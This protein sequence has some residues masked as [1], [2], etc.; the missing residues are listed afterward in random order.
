LIS[1]EPETSPIPSYDKVSSTN[2]HPSLPRCHTL[3]AM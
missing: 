2:G 1:G 3:I